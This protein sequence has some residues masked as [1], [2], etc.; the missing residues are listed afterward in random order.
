M[1]DYFTRTAFLK[2]LQTQNVC[3]PT[4]KPCRPNGQCGCD[5]EMDTCIQS[6]RAPA[7]VGS[8]PTGGRT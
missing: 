3:K 5:C 2:Y 4:G 8:P 7:L 6:E 1:S